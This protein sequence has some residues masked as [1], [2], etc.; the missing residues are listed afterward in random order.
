MTPRIAPFLITK[1]CKLAHEILPK[2]ISKTYCL[3][4]LVRERRVGIA[5][6]K[7]HS[8]LDRRFGLEGFGLPRQ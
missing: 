4:A 6:T 8:V 3:P 7:Y 5:A 2:I 1:R